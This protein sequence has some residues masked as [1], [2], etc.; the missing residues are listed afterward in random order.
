MTSVR[1]VLFLVV[2]LCLA[3]PMA[4]A[5]AEACSKSAPSFDLDLDLLLAAPAE[6]APAALPDPLPMVNFC[7]K[8]VCSVN[9][10]DCRAGCAPCGFV[11][12]CNY[13]GCYSCQCTC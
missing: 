9:R 11:F 6:V 13:P 5:A 2:A 3:I 12:Q 10:Q 1:R 8:E 7:T 4:G